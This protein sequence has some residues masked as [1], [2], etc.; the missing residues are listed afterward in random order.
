MVLNYGEKIL[1]KPGRTK[2]SERRSV[3]DAVL[4]TPRL[5]AFIKSGLAEE[6]PRAEPDIPSRSEERSRE[7]V[8]HEP[9]KPRRGRPRRAATY[10]PDKRPRVEPAGTSSVLDD[11]LV[12][13]TTKLRRRTLQALR[14]AY[15]EQKLAD[16]TPATQQEIIEEAVAGWLMENGFRIG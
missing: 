7:E 3:T 10:K 6:P 16:R 1:M 9:A 15:L 5:N 4:A 2:M 12:P 11:I 14:R 13:V 8:P